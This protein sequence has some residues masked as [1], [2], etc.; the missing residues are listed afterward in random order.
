[1]K[2]IEEVKED[3]FFENNFRKDDSHSEFKISP[4][5]INLE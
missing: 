3:D 2:E 5:H 1:M 4:V